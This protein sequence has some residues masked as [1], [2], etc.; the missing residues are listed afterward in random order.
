METFKKTYIYI[1][2]FEPWANLDKNPTQTIVESIEEDRS[3]IELP[4]GSELETQVLEVS[5]ESSKNELDSL[6]KK[7][8]SKHQEKKQK[9]KQT[10]FK[11]NVI[12]LHF[13]LYSGSHNLQVER[14]AFNEATWRGK[15]QRGLMS[16]YQQI[17][18]ENGPITHTFN[19]KFDVEKIVENL[20]SKEYKI[21][22]SLDPGRFLCNWVYYYSLN[23]SD[24]IQ[25]CRSLFVHFPEFDEIGLDDD[26]RFVSDL[27][28]FLVDSF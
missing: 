23:F 1:T 28:S 7:I 26:I 19:T 3:K 14:Q 9:K 10:V 24:K 12:L 22:S 5:V 17:I 15:D 20:K 21:I 13:G 25:N 6:F 16:L 11:D 18:P 27:I 4:K 2:A 8:K